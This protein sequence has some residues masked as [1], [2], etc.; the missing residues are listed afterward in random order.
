M[1][2]IGD[3]DVGRD[4]E[5]QGEQEML[6]VPPLHLRR[7]IKC[8]G[9]VF[10]DWRV[11]VLLGHPQ[12]DIY[13]KMLELGGA[14]VERWTLHHL[15]DLQTNKRLSGNI[16]IISRP[17]YLLMKDFRYLLYQNKSEKVCVI[18]YIYIGDF[19][20]RKQSPPHRMY[21][22]R[23]PEMWQLVEDCK[24]RKQLLDLHLPVWKCQDDDLW[25]K[26]NM[27]DLDITVI[28]HTEN[29]ASHISET[30]EM[31][32]KKQ[33][34]RNVLQSHLA[35][36][37]QIVEDNRQCEESCDEIKIVQETIG[38][39]P[40]IVGINIKDGSNNE[41]WKSYSNPF[42]DTNE[43]IEIM[44][45]TIRAPTLAGIQRLKNRAAKLLK[46]QGD[47]DVCVI[48]PPRECSNV[49]SPESRECNRNKSPSSGDTKV[50]GH[51]FNVHTSSLSKP[52]VRNQEIWLD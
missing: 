42:T 8:K 27:E 41:S 29:V 16:L 44:K 34:R 40:G 14:V 48:N 1:D 19:L 15:L 46:I 18:T 5:Q 33:R 13:R 10:Q 21:D 43:E 32:R 2:N 7:T 35:S 4:Q 31:Q 3:Y 50:R 51:S 26:N 37:N 36:K 9:G 17:S 38:A 20:T 25:N 47:Q 39:L 28:E 30:P 22:V 12:M 11:V 49:K 52:S 45:E 23:N 24:V 6:Y